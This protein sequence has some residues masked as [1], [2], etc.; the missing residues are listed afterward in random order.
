M[1]ESLEG[2]GKLEHKR[3]NIIYQLGDFCRAHQRPDL[4]QQGLEESHAKLYD[5]QTCGELRNA[6]VP[7]ST[8]G[9]VPPENWIVHV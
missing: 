3:H 1:N 6:C 2:G 8:A 4:G 7:L 5:S 9:T